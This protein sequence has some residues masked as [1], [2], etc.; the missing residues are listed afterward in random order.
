MNRVCFETSPVMFSS[1]AQAFQGK[2]SNIT[3][4]EL[5][6]DGIPRCHKILLPYAILLQTTSK[7]RCEPT[8]G[9]ITLSLEYLKLPLD[10]SANTD[11]KPQEP[12]SP[13]RLRSGCLQH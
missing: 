8:P 2:P 5:D 13:Q 10:M 9:L 12:A 1:I 6:V 7:T 4:L 3:M 11:A